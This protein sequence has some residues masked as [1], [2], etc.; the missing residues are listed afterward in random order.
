M[1]EKKRGRPS[2]SPG[3]TPAKVQVYVS[4]SDYDRA[5]EAARREG[6]SVPALMRDALRR[7]LDSDED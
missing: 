5:A 3:E 7:R 4:P 6:L 2:V 1:A